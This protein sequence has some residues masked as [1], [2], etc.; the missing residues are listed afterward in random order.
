MKKFIFKL[1]PDH[2]KQL[3]DKGVLQIKPHAD[4]ELPWK[5]VFTNSAHEIVEK[6]CE[7]IDRLIYITQDYHHAEDLPK[8]SEF[9]AFLGA[10]LR[11]NNLGECITTQS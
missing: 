3:E 5:F 10:Y 7:H 8:E 1:E 4:D 6:P 9:A 2:V 11:E